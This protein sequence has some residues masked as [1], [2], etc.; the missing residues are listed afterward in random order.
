MAVIVFKADF[1]RIFLACLM[2]EMNVAETELYENLY[3]TW[4]LMSQFLFFRGGESLD[5]DPTWIE[6]LEVVCFQI[7]IRQTVHS[8]K[9]EAVCLPFFSYRHYNDVHLKNMLLQ[10]HQ[11]KGGIY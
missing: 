3:M 6:R 9:N 8:T 11:W 2:H 5:E 4:G 10:W 7:S 1:E